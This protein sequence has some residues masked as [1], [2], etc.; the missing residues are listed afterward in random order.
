[1]K[2]E[3]YK[4][5]QRSTGSPAYNSQTQSDDELRPRS[6]SATVSGDGRSGGKTENKNQKSEHTTIKGRFKSN[7]SMF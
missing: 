5:R 7:A 6:Q 2:Q 3:G 1:M 4:H